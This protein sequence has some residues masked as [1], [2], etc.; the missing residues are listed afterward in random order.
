[1]IFNSK[2]KFNLSNSSSLTENLYRKNYGEILGA[3]LPKIGMEN[4][5]I[6]EEAVNTSFE[7]AIS[8]WSKT[9]FPENPIAWLHKVSYTTA[10]DFLRREKLGNA[11][12]ELWVQ[13]EEKFSIQTS[14]SN[15]E[16]ENSG[17]DDLSKMILLC[18]NPLIN[19]KAQVCLTLKSVCGFSIGEIGKALG[20]Q[21][22]AVKKILTR[23]KQEISKNPKVLLELDEN[24]I[25]ERF[26]LVL[27][28]L[29]ALFNEGYSASSGE[30]QFSEEITEEAI[31]ISLIL[32]E[33]K[34]THW[35]R[36]GELEA[37]IA[38]MFFQVSRLSVRV[39]NDGFPIRL[40]EQNRKL[41]NRELI[42]NG[43]KFLES[44]Q[45]SNW[46][47]SLHLEARIAAEHA[48]SQSFQ[49]TNWKK[50]L[51]CYDDLL[52]LKDTLPVRLNRIVAISYAENTN[53]AFQELEKFEI[54]ENKSKPNFIQT[55]FL[56]HCVK[57]D[58][59]ERIGN[60]ELAR[61]HWVLAKINAPTGTDKKFTEKKI[62]NC[63]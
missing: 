35:E 52:K 19:E 48:T 24:R 51:Q 60:K 43:L 32:L 62:Q 12:V 18:C 4:Y 37:L 54:V 28:T 3:L 17:I 61:N 63:P 10:I 40:Q 56:F 39:A 59:L 13:E 49:T 20:M 31:R 27:D 50:I 8:A 22:E 15:Y 45:K 42:F 25:K 55:S 36:R 9:G 58:L 38:L 29:Y 34:Y 14:V 23:A 44:S 1:M 6:A 11:K 21:E 53:R 7:K 46:L 16:N 57:A 26:S 30:S 47:T 2:D 41:W 5:E 33:S